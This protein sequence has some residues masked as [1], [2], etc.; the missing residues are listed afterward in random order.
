MTECAAD[1]AARLRVRLLAHTH[2]IGLS[3]KLQQLRTT[4]GTLNYTQLVIAQGAHPAVPDPL[5]QNLCWRIND[6]TAWRRVRDALKNGAKRIR[7]GLP[8]RF[9]HRRRSSHTQ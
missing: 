8:R 5:L 3:P 7:A 2:A 1:G 6:L 4:R 9:P